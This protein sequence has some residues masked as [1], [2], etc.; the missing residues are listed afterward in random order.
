MVNQEELIGYPVGDTGFKNTVYA[1]FS[2]GEVTIVTEALNSILTFTL[3]NTEIGYYNLKLMLS[4]DN[5]SI[6]LSNKV[7]MKSLNSSNKDDLMF[8]TNLIALLLTTSLIM[9]RKNEKYL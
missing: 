5:K 6:L 4:S 9:K 7:F 1:S 3:S 2:D 8:I